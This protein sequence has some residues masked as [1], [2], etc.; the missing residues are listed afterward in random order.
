[1][2]YTSSDF[3]LS[4]SLTSEARILIRQ[5]EIVILQDANDT[6][7]GKSMITLKSGQIRKHLKKY[8]NRP[9]VQDNFTCG[10]L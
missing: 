7:S 5:S 4:L 9:K 8:R 3:M 1:M 2:Y 6:S 10:N